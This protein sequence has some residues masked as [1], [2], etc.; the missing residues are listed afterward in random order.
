MGLLGMTRLFLACGEKSFQIFRQKLCA[1]WQISCLEL[2][3]GD[4]IL[5]RP[6]RDIEEAGNVTN[7]VGWLEVEPLQGE[8]FQKEWVFCG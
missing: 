8:E 7:G 6:W 5:D 1:P 3:R 4:T 2:P